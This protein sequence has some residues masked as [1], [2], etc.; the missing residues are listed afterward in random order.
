M[1]FGTD[2]GGERELAVMKMGLFR[3]I[4][5]IPLIVSVISL[6]I[7]IFFSV[8]SLFFYREAEG[9]VTKYAQ[10]I[11]VALLLFAITFLM[12]LLFFIQSIKGLVADNNALMASTENVNQ[13]FSKQYLY[14]Y[15][16]SNISQM[17]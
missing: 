5:I 3:G 4:K 10:L 9:Y 7:L 1:L 13:K 15:I 2:F 17:M 8:T 14:S 11:S 16:T 6:C 12:N